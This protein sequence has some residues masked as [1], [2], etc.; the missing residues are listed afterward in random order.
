MKSYTMYLTQGNEEVEV[1]LRLDIE[2]LLA[3]KK[4]YNSDM[5]IDTIL[6][7]VSDPEMCVFI[8]G[9][10]LKYKG[11]T[12]E[13]ASGKEFYELLVDNDKAGMEGIWD[14]LINIARVSG[15]VTEKMSDR[16]NTKIT[17]KFDNLFED[18]DEGNAESQQAK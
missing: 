5:I 7:A 2:G 11:N 6:S 8:F 16:L 12:N 15:I 4:K 9:Q 18:D 3:V 17:S 10:A 14:V 13:I 1:N